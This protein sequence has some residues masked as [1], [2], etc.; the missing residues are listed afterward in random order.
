M[1]DRDTD[2]LKDE[3]MLS[4]GRGREREGVEGTTD[5]QRKIGSAGER[6]TAGEERKS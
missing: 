6:K 2:E 1:N 3:R 5:T 4:H